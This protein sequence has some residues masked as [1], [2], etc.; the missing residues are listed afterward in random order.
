MRKSL[1]RHQEDLG[2]ETNRLVPMNGIP[3]KRGGCAEGGIID[4]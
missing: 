1:E 2:I 4:I 3:R